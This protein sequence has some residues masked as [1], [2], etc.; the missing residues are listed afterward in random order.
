MRANKARDTKPELCL[1]KAL[2]RRG[3]PGYRLHW[4]KAPGK[5]D[6]S[7]PGRRLAI[8]VHGC[9]WHRCPHC[10]LP[11][12]KSHVDFWRKK[13]DNNRERDNRKLEALQR[14]G[15]KAL[16]FWECQ[17]NRDPDLCAEQVK[18]ALSTDKVGE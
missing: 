1:R 10:S 5:P 16:V 11:L 14:H 12:P 2:R 18:K 9:F 17:I 3:V 13:F 15:W 7:Y 4:G 8:F 6:I